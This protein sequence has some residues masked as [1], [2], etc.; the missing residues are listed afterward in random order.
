MTE[1][2]FHVPCSRKGSGMRTSQL[3]SRPWELFLPSRKNWGSVTLWLGSLWSLKL[4]LKLVSWVD[5]PAGRWLTD[6]QWTLWACN[7]NTKLNQMLY[8][9][10]MLAFT[11]L[12]K[13]YLFKNTTC[14]DWADVLPHNRLTLMDDSSCNNPLAI[15]GSRPH[16][17]I[18]YRAQDRY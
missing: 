14:E 13:W 17:D 1:G 15:T 2:P 16:R 10:D 5:A 12:S 18:K 7:P 8:W 4:K 6:R 3:F 11:Y 9:Q